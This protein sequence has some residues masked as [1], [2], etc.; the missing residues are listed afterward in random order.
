MRRMRLLESKLRLYDYERVQQMTGVPA[1]VIT[2]SQFIV[3]IALA[4]C[5]TYPVV[6]G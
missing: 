6:L 1:P 5:V 3:S 4:I 2:K